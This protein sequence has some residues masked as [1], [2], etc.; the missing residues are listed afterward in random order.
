MPIEERNR[1]YEILIRFG[2]SGEVAGAQYQTIYELVNGDKILS[3]TV[4]AP[5]S[6]AVADG[7]EGLNLADVLGE[8]SASAITQNIQL[9]SA[10]QAVHGELESYTALAEQAQAD[11]QSQIEALQAQL[12]A[13]AALAASPGSTVEDTPQG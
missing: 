11:L 9:Q 13:A 1:P 5:I 12:A 10:L 2:T 8:V 7:V 3:A 6:L 4:N